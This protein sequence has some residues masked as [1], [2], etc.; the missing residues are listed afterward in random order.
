MLENSLINYSADTNSNNLIKRTNWDL[1]SSIRR[2][3][4]DKIVK[5]LKKKKK[6]SPIWRFPLAATCPWLV[7]FYTKNKFYRDK[8]IT[9]GVNHGIKIITWPNLPNL[10]LHENSENCRLRWEKLFC[11]ELDSSID[12]LS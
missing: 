10:N 5:I 9:W 1:L 8:I 11:I 6:C 4:W 3:R 12:N 7:P 2:K